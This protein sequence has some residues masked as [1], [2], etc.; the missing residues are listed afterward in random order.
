MLI[1]GS[2]ICPK[3]LLMWEE[4]EVPGGNSRVQ[5]GNYNTVLHTTLADPQDRTRIAEVRIK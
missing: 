3:G 4:I 5:V 2:D 1:V